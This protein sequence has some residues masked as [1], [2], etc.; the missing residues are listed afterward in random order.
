MQLAAG[1]Y[2]DGAVPIELDF[3]QPVWTF[4]EPIFL[5]QEHSWDKVQR[6]ETVHSSDA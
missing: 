1:F 3:A 2:G 4:R 6:H 5:E